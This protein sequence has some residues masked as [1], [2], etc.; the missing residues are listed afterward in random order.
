MT[1]ENLNQ[2]Y[3]S[4]N[5]FGANTL[6]AQFGPLTWDDSFQ[7]RGPPFQPFRPSDVYKYFYP[8]SP[9]HPFQGLLPDNIRDPNDNGVAVEKLQYQHEFTPS[10]YVRVYGYSLYSNWDINGYNSDA[11]PY[12]GWELPYFLP[13]HTH[14][15]NLSYVNQA[16]LAALAERRGRL[17]VLEP[18]A[19]L[20]YVLSLRLEH[21]ELRRLERQVLRSVDG[22]ADRLLRPNAG[23]AHESRSRRLTLLVQSQPEAAGVRCGDQPAVAR[24]QYLRAGKSGAQSGRTLLS[25]V[26]RSTTNGVPTTA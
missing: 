24:H 6:F 11:Q 17:Y 5:D 26:T 7:Y 15:F 22:P 18:S 4:I 12:Y 1:S 14:G 19:I 10:S 9:P 21:H 3:S 20:R 23:N 16:Q 13:D 2:Y 8:S 25:R